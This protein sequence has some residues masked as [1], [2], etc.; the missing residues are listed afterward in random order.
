MYGGRALSGN[1]GSDETPLPKTLLGFDDSLFG[2]VLFF[3]A[4]S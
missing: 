3:L 1:L 2:F 4:K